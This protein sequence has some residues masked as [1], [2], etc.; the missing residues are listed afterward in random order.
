MTILKLA[1]LGS[2]KVALFVYTLLPSDASFAG[3][4][5]EGNGHV[6]DSTSYGATESSGYGNADIG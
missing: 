3:A 6:G 4:K 1:L 5:T 2:L